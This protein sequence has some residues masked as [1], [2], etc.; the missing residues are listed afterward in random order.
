MGSPEDELGRDADET[1]HRVT[2]T[3]PFLL[4]QTEVTQGLYEEVMG[5]LPDCLN[6]TRTRG[7]DFPM[8]CVSWDDAVVFCAKLSALERLPQGQQYRLPTEAEWEYAARAGTDLAWAGTSRL[9]DLCRFGNVQRNG[10]CYDEFV[11][12]A[13]VGRF[14][15]N[16][17]GLYNMSGNV[18]E[19]TAD[20][21]G[22]Y[23]AEAT[24]PRGGP[25]RSERVSRGGSWASDPAGARVAR[26]SASDTYWRYADLGFRLARSLPPDP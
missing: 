23:A 24:D 4:G 22:A 6:G 15:A 3:R 17:L 13:P 7:E 19:W 8:H 2:L 11:D 5:E 26:R 18:F 25:S 20:G 12:L 16:A 21:D 14:R 9:K 1:R 10:G